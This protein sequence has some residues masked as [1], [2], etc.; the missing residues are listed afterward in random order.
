[1]LYLAIVVGGVTIGFTLAAMFSVDAYEKGYEDG[2][3]GK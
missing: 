2:R 1:M 3:G